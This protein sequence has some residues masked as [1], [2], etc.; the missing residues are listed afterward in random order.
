MDKLIMV[1]EKNILF[2]P[3]RKIFQWFCGKNTADYEGCILAHYEPMKRGIAEENYDY[4]QPITYGLLVNSKTQTVFAYQRA[5]STVQFWEARLQG[6]WSWGLGG[7]VDYEDSSDEN[8]I[9]LSLCRE[10]EE[11][12]WVKIS[13]SDIHVLGYINDDLDEVGKVHLWILYV[14]ETNLTKIPS[15]APELA[16]GDF[17]TIEELESISQNP[18][19]TV[20]NWSQIALGPLKA[21]LKNHSN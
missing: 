10:F 5:M 1:I 8:P 2:T 13:D 9:H 6:K 18:D 3:E 11:E 14:I 20:E 15:L 7:H 4:K 16:L 17:K 19:F 21:Y 12:V